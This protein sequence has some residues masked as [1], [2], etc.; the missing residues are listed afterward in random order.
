[1]DLRFFFIFLSVLIGLVI[2][3][4]IIINKSK[5]SRL[6]SIDDNG[7]PL[8]LKRIESFDDNKYVHGVFKSVIS[9][10]RL[11]DGWTSE[12]SWDRILFK[13][14]P[15][16]G[17]GGI[18]LKVNYDIVSDIF[19]IKKVTLTDEFERRDFTCSVDDLVNDE[20]L[21]IYKHYS[22]SIE[23]ENND[24]KAI[25]DRSLSNIRSV[26]GKSADRDDKINK[27]LEK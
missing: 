7:T 23:A 17:A 22:N 24:R 18:T 2:S 15:T 12:V 25:I 21:T 10:I 9:S 16:S 19:H 5:S 11:E 13:K 6:K 27:I 4:V 8:V 1:M 26:I 3:I 14:K 20:I